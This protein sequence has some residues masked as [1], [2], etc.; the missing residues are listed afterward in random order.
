MASYLYKPAMSAAS[1]M[2]FLW[3]RRSLWI[4]FGNLDTGKFVLSLL[5]ETSAS[6]GAV[7]ILIFNNNEVKYNYLY[8]YLLDTKKT[9][10]RG[11]N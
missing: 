11:S 1:Q 4:L 10:Y 6:R 8:C 7:N 5:L 3:N 9:S 2:L